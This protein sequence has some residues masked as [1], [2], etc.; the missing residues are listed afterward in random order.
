MA[1]Y[2]GMFLL[3]N[4]QANRDW[5]GAVAAVKKTLSDHGAEMHRMDKWAE[6]KLAYPIKGQK[7]GTYLLTYFA[8]EEDTPNRIYRDVEISGVILRA[9]ILKIDRLPP[10]PERPEEEKPKVEAAEP[11]GPP[12]KAPEPVEEV[13]AAA[14]EPAPP[15]VGEEKEPDEKGE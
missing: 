6:R 12:P 3:D 7:R 14:A 15:E 4:R 2:E 8:A 9:L 1:L 11:K 13:A 5:D 10:E